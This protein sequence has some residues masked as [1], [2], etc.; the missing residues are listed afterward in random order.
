MG[1]I[2]MWKKRP[3]MTRNFCK[4]IENQ[5]LVHVTLKMNVSFF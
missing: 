3:I 1:K 4:K 2:L 5:K